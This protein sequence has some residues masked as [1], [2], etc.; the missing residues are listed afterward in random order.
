MPGA[1]G[2]I[3]PAL[4]GVRDKAVI[5]PLPKEEDVLAETSS[6]TDEP[7]PVAEEATQ[8]PAP[9]QEV[10][11]VAPIRTVVIRDGDTL[12]R[13]SRRH[14]VS[15][16]ALRSLNDLRDNRIVTGRTLRLPEPGLHQTNSQAS[17]GALNR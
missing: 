14:K 12:W 3:V 17:L 2:G 6:V 15:L 5:L 9:V 13:L 1:D 16:D 8:G 4:T 7:G 11:P 10:V